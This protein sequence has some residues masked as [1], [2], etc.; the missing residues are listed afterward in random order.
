M[1]EQYCFLGWLHHILGPFI[2]PTLKQQGTV[3]VHCS[4]SLFKSWSASPEAVPHNNGKQNRSLGLSAGTCSMQH[5]INAIAII[6]EWREK[7]NVQLK[8]CLVRFLREFTT[9]ERCQTEGSGKHSPLFNHSAGKEQEQPCKP[10]PWRPPQLSSHVPLALCRQPCF[11]GWEKIWVFTPLHCLFSLLT[12]PFTSSLVH[13]WWGP[14]TPPKRAGRYHLLH[15]RSLSWAGEQKAPSYKSPPVPAQGC[16]RGR[17]GWRRAETACCCPAGAACTWAR[18]GRVRLFLGWEQSEG[19]AGE[20]NQPP[21]AVWAARRSCGGEAGPRWNGKSRGCVARQGQ[22]CGVAQVE[23][24]P[25]CL[26]SGGLLSELGSPSEVSHRALSH[27]SFQQPHARSHSH[28]CPWTIWQASPEEGQSLL[29]LIYSP[30]SRIRAHCGE[31]HLWPAGF[32]GE[33]VTAS[34]L[35]R[36]WRAPIFFC[37]VMD[38]HILSPNC[39]FPKAKNLHA[40]S[41]PPA[42]SGRC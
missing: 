34:S 28:H 19:R 20:G 15:V 10:P 17:R 14:L 37:N 6:L 18:P 31:L 4:C 30:A 35:K 39:I 23:M 11:T 26:S 24:K 7:Q 12:P 8:L 29:S 3:E 32:W 21:P 2:L 22:S 33:G 5:C 25:E 42:P 27:S 1:V 38:L 16:P 13:L 40:V 36:S 9:W 41:S